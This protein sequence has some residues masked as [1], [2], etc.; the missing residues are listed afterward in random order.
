MLS[1]Q[2]REFGGFWMRRPALLISAFFATTCGSE[3]A[4]VPQAISSV[5][6]TP[7]AETVPPNSTVDYSA[8]ALDATGHAVAGAPAPVWSS[9]D[10]GV[11]VD[12]AGHATIGSFGALTQVIV[13]ARIAGV[14]GTAQLTVDP[15][16][17]PVDHIVVSGGG[18]TMTS[19]GQTSQFSA[20]SR[21]AAGHP[22]S[23]AFTWS[24]SDAST[25][26]VDSTGLATAL[27]NTSTPV[28]ITASTGG[29][30]GTAQLTV[31]QAVHH[32]VVSPA[33]ATVAK[34]A[35]KSFTPTPQDANNNNI[36]GTF[37]TS[38][39]TSDHN[40]ATIN[41]SGV[42]TGVN[43]GGPISVSATISARTGTAQLTVTSP[44]VV[45]TIPW[46]LRTV[47]NLTIPVGDSIQWQSTDGL[48]HTATS[49]TV[50][51]MGCTSTSAFSWDTG[52]FSTTSVAINFTQAGTFPYCCSPHG[53]ASMS[54]TITVQ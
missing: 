38:W 34:G 20:R 25:V 37:T 5:R 16:F 33:T 30:S 46:H 8:A 45:H 29:K 43:V 36:P 15:H 47:Q 51:S 53:C 18:V 24:S 44:V 13:T 3:S 2:K 6:V 28:T 31:Q 35:T 54:G 27:A 49:C 1:L 10:A 41:A 32:I 19:I 23:R 39:D 14:A 12:S 52:S 26:S 17:V 48:S 4:R 22:L 42:A 40:I 50:G 7:A 11:T 9:D 21:D